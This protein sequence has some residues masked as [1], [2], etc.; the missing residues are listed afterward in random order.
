MYWP[1]AFAAGCMMGAVSPAV[2]VPT[3]IR[4]NSLGYGADKGISGIVIAASSLDDILAISLFGVFLGIGMGGEGGMFGD[5]PT[6]NAA[7]TGPFELV[8]GVILG[9]LIGLSLRTQWFTRIPAR[10][11]ALIL[12]SL[13]MALTFLWGIINMSG[14]GYLA[15]I[16]SASIGATHWGNDEADAVEAIVSYAWLVL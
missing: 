7:L 5:N 6:V 2:V 16:S 10:Y 12:L 13:A 14:L 3:C 8:A 4:L 1:L 15:T 11:K 9:I